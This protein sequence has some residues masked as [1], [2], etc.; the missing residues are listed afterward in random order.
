V[1]L[2]AIDA[3]HKEKVLIGQT[4]LPISDTYRRAF[5]EFIDKNQLGEM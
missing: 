1:S 4:Y 3:I 2:D 5:K